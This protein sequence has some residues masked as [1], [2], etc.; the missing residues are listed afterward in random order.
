MID[1]ATLAKLEA[2][3]KAA[4]R[5]IPGEWKVYRC[6]YCEKDSA[7]GINERGFDCSHDECHHPLTLAECAHIAAF[8]PPLALELIAAA[9]EREQLRGELEQARV[10]L[11][12]C[13]IAAEGGPTEEVNQGDWSW[14]LALETTRDLR[15]ERDMLSKEFDGITSLLDEAGIEQ[16]G[17]QERVCLLL[18]EADEIRE[19]RKDIRREL[20]EARG[21]LEKRCAV[22]DIAEHLHDEACRERDEARAERDAAQRLAQNRAEG[23][24]G[25]ELRA[26]EWAGQ[27]DELHAEMRAMAKVSADAIEHLQ[28]ALLSQ[29]QATDEAMRRVEEARRELAA[30]RGYAQHLPSCASENGPDVACSCGLPR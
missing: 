13:L 29:Q 30:V 21:E 8:C 11:A 26:E 7:C 9:R 4:S 14:T 22:A 1:E 17:L 5:E 20:D 23:V 24:A 19:D 3:A 15:R 18:I 25:A 12:G 6:S 10:Q 2:I 27:C 28:T 16:D